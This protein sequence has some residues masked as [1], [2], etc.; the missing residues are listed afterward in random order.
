[1]SALDAYES[2]P[3]DRLSVAETHPDHLAAL[4]RLYGIDCPDPRSSRVLELGCAAGANL[5]PMAWFLPRARFV[6]LDISAHQVQNGQR[7]IDTLGLDNIQIRRADVAE[8]E[9]E[10][11]GFDYIIAHGLYSWVPAPVRGAL[12]ALIRRQLRPRGIA[13]LSFNALPGWHMRGMLREMLLF[14][15]RAFGEPLQRVQAARE[16][17]GTLETGLTGLEALS[18][19]YLLHEMVELKS[20]PDS[21]LYHEY[22]TTINEPVLFTGF[23][24]EACQA[25]LKYLCNA[26]LRYQFPAMLGDGA[27][28]MLSVF[29]DPL[30]RQQYLD[31]LINRNFHQALLVRDDTP[32]LSEPDIENF[33][34]LALYSDLV[35]PQRLDL[36]KTK[37]Q[38]FTDTAGQT[39]AVKHPLTKAALNHLSAVYPRAIAYTELEQIAQQQ[40][41]AAGDRRLAEQTD[42]LFGELFYLFIDGVLFVSPHDGGGADTPADE[43]PCANAL[44]RLEAAAARL[45][46][47]RHRSL[48]LD[49]VTRQMIN[50][51]DGALDRHELATRLRAI[52]PGCRASDLA[53]LID[54]LARR[55]AL[56]G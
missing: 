8:V 50:L 35:A 48:L 10:G 30:Q 21:Y 28:H 5:I 31:F 42:H 19:S 39:V 26:D 11:E 4:A 32:A 44:A 37:A 52:D 29:S 12:L 56:R 54:S 34:T 22:L 24:D 1:M 15:V 55:G 49:D 17:L 16:F 33:S 6:G 14:H 46:D 41:A 9:L 53:P 25:G 47:S 40:V 43:P 51:M 38:S 36:R 27:E 7:D 23:V 13:Y 20:A 45:V 18:A 2:L 3:Y